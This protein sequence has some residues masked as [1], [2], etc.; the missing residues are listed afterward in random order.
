MKIIFKYLIAVLLI[1]IVLP[2]VVVESF[3]F[4]PKGIE[5]G[6]DLVPEKEEEEKPK[7]EV[8]DSN[9]NKIEMDTVKVYDPHKGETEELDIEE[10]VVGVVAAEMPAE[11]HEEALK[12][13]AVA[14][15]TYAIKRTLSYE[16]G[17]KDHPE[18]P[19]CKDVHCQ[20]HLSYEELKTTKGDDWIDK[21]LGKI[22]EAVSETEGLLIY[23]N[24]EVAEPLY[25]S[26]SGG[27]TEDAVN[28][29]A[30]DT[31][32]LKSVE[33]PYEE[34]SPR[35]KTITTIPS[36][37]FINKIKEK[38]PEVD[39]TKENFYEKIKL[40]EKSSSGRIITIAVDEEIL[41]GRDIRD[42]FNLYSTNFNI[43]YNEKLNIVD[44]ETLGYGHGVGMSQWGANGMAK[45]GHDFIEI[46]TH[47][48]KGTEIR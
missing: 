13:Q 11:F 15:R 27:M 3:S 22:E 25:H 45:E 40:I 18:A 8:L 35:F 38:Y 48:Y 16:N 41:H 14:A 34:D 21:Y 42:I 39:L 23:Y 24:G 36:E 9:I 44:I 19:L 43:K 12:A 5:V 4:A 10:Y 30:A 17:H 33:S 28:V 37:E 7:Q 20:A 31:P 32:Y 1:V 26:T 6:R 2:T 29:F 46:L 47:Y